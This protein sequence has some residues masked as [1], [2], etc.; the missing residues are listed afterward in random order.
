MPRNSL[1]WFTITMSITTGK[2]TPGMLSVVVPE[3]SGLTLY[4]PWP[5]RLGAMPL[6]E[7]LSF[8]I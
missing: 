3:Q 7:P 1:P 8:E 2:G 6:R 5:A 4:V